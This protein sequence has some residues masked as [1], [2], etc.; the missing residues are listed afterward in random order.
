[1]GLPGGSDLGGEFT[2]PTF[3]GELGSEQPGKQGETKA[4]Y[5]RHQKEDQY[6]E[7]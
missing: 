7:P 2:R 3:T 1:M 6:P 4:R 5:D